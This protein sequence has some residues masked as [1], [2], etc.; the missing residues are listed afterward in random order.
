MGRRL[1]ARAGYVA[2][3][4]LTAKQRAKL[5]DS[6]SPHLTDASALEAALAAVRDAIA[7][8]LTALQDMRVNDPSP[9]REQTLAELEQLRDRARS[10]H[11]AIAALS[12][13][14]RA[15]LRELARIVQLAETFEAAPF[16]EPDRQRLRPLVE[17]ATRAHGEQV[18]WRRLLADGQLEQAAESS[19]A[20]FSAAEEAARR[21]ASERQP[22]GRRP[23]VAARMFVR[24]LA[25]IWRQFTG[26]PLA[27]GGERRQRK[28][29]QGGP[30]PAGTRSPWEHFV[31]TA[32][33][34]AGTGLKGERLAR[35][36]AERFR[37]RTDSRGKRGPR[38]GIVSEDDS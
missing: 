12:E 33:E 6:L 19:L 18:P 34:V 9:P 32:L 8:Y 11:N 21:C 26:E 27:R 17:A 35:E 37:A 14:A 3:V 28:P 5:A 2:P 4:R 1:R 25:Q 7:H 16:S 23:N 22:P 30:S 13:E 38:A 31:C 10:L 29:E 20:V 36:V 15:R 24:Q